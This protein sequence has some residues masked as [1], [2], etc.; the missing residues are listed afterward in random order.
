MDRRAFVPL[1]PGPSPLESLAVRAQQSGKVFR[2]GLLVPRTE[3][4]RADQIALESLRTALRDLGWVEGKNL[5]IETRWASANPQRQRE[6]AAE[7]K[8]LPVALILALGTT[9][10]RAARDGAPGLPIIMINAGDP[11]GAGFAATL[12]RPGSDLTG[13]SAVGHED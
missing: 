7:L 5:V 1:L 6:L 10:I 8:A 9:A 11:V 12:A 2:I 13:T 4:E 3:P